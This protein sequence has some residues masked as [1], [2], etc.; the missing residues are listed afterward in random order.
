[1]S[2]PIFRQ[3]ALERLSS[4]EQ[5]DQLMPVTSLRAWAALLAL[6]LILITAFGWSLVGTLPTQVAGH[7]ILIRGGQVLRVASPVPGQIAAVFVNVGHDV[8]TGQTIASLY[9]VDGASAPIIA[10]FSGRVVELLVGP[11]SVVAA[12]DGI[13][14]LD[15]VSRPLEAVVYVSA[16]DGKRIQPGLSVAVSPVNVSPEQFGFMR[17]VVRSVAP[18]PATSQ[19][20][21]LVL[22][23]DQLVSE[24]AAAGAPIEVRIDLQ[25]D[26]RTPSGYAWAAA[27]LAGIENDI[28]L[29]PMGMHTVITEGGATFS[30]GQRQRL[31]IARAIVARPRILFFDEATSALDNRTQAIVGQSL[32]SLQATRLVVAHRLSTILLADRIYVLEAGRVVQ[33]GSYPELAGQEGPFRD[34]IKRQVV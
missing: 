21:M 27:R 11:G 1:M 26:S 23:N 30:D 3:V 15:N 19:S 22:A 13:A 16:P 8:Q 18:F 10:A 24:F 12:G 6:L 28:R 25:P 29:M 9:T 32:E 5:L 2:K 7:G 33:R 20:M 4:P 17:G 31:M 14:N 34:L